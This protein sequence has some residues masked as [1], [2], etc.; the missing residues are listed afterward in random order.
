MRYE[1]IINKENKTVKVIDTLLEDTYR[2][3]FNENGFV[4]AQ[5]R[6]ELS[7]IT[8]ALFKQTGSTQVK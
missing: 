2:G 3:T 6:I 8:K 4:T 5:S 7:M 1:I